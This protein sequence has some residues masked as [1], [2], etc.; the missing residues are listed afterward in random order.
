MQNAAVLILD[1]ELTPHHTMAINSQ[2]NKFAPTWH[3]TLDFG[4]CYTRWQQW[5][6]TG[7][8][9]QCGGSSGIVLDVVSY[10]FV[11]A[12]GLHWAVSYNLV[13]AVGL[14]MWSVYTVVAAVGLHWVV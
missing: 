2:Y 14:H 5:D 10:T 12:V 6:C 9:L 3:V 11:A 7:G 1:S 4:V 13:A 8:Q